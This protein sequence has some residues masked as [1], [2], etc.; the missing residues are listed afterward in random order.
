M[1][2]DTKSQTAYRTRVL[3]VDDEKRIRDGCHSILT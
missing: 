3:V 1:K 2:D